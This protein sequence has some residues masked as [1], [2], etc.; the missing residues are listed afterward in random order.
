MGEK[1]DGATEQQTSPQ[2]PRPFASS[3]AGVTTG[4]GSSPRLAVQGDSASRWSRA[5][6]ASSSGPAAA[7]LSDSE[8]ACGAG[9]AEPA[10]VLGSSPSGLCFWG[11]KGVV[12]MRPGHT[13][14][15]HV[16]CVG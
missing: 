10:P 12:L 2:T 9:G 15:S 6:Q 7:G 5:P 11:R 4:L 13:G 1:A 8:A 16:L 14:A 3:S